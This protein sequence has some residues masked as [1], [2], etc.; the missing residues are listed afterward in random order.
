M[1]IR[2]EKIGLD[3]APIVQ[4]ILESSPDYYRNVARSEVLPHFAVR[5]MQDEVPKVRQ[6]PTYEKVFCLISADGHPVG[7]VDLHKDHPEKGKCYL[8]LLVIDGRQQNKG[9]G[10]MI[11]PHIESFIATHLSCSEVRLGVSESNDVEGF[12]RKVGFKRNGRHYEWKGEEYVNT[13]FEMTK[14]IPTN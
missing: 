2:I 5:E 9:Y 4:K 1:N 8:G 6:S 10:R 12:W 3:R 11:Y 14:M 7:I 13:V